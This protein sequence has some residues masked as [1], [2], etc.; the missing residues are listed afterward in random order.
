MVVAM[1]VVII[2][3]IA[4]IVLGIAKAIAIGGRRCSNCSNSSTRT[5]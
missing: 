5:C 2:I 3:L 1:A 4:S